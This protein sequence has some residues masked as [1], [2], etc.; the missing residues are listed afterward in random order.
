MKLEERSGAAS[1]IAC[2]SCRRQK[3]GTSAELPARSAPGL[4]QYARVVENDKLCVYKVT[5][6]IWNDEGQACVY[7]SEVGGAEAK[8]VVDLPEP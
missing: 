7:L 8:R 2:V 6:V 1:W 4:G 3:R 5:D